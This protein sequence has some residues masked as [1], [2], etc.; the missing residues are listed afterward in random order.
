MRSLA[1]L[2]LPPPHPLSPFLTRMTCYLSSLN[3][4][5]LRLRVP[6]ECMFSR[7]GPNLC[8]NTASMP[9]SGKEKST[10]SRQSGK[11]VV[12]AKQEEPLRNRGRED[13]FRVKSV[14]L[15][16]LMH[17]CHWNP[18]R[19]DGF[20]LDWDTCMY[21]RSALSRQSYGKGRSG[22][23]VEGLHTRPERRDTD[24][25]R[26]EFIALKAAP[27]QTVMIGIRR[28]THGHTRM[29][30]CTRTRSL[31]STSLVR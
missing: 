24:E 21:Q 18:G 23:R 4:S 13:R 14:R 22:G 8:N 16:S 19:Q 10:L 15:V 2:F 26:C 9:R 31:L 12:T 17:K 25:T 5:N 6:L 28:G 11:F 30:A 7:Q 20:G 3:L 29:H 27:S 1:H